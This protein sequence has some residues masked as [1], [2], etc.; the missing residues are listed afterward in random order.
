MLSAAVRREKERKR[1]KRKERSFSSGN[2]EATIRQGRVESAGET[3]EWL[4]N[5]LHLRFV[6]LVGLNF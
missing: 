1:R 5:L 3:S 4:S 2:Q 6:I